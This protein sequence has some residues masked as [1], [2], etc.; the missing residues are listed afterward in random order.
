MKTRKEKRESNKET[1]YFFEFEKII[2]HF[3]KG[4]QK[5]LGKVEDGRHS[6]YISYPAELILYQMILKNAV[7][8]RSMRGMSE[9]FNQEK[10]IE[11]LRIA[12]KLKKLEEIPHYDTVNDFLSKLAPENLERIR[13]QM[14]VSLLK[15]RC[16]EGGR[17]LRKYWHVVVDGTGLHRFRERHCEHC[18]KRV[19]TDKETGEI[20]TYYYH[21]VLEAKLIVGKMALSLAT[22]FIENESVDVEKQDCEIKAFY[23]LSKKLKKDY[24]RLP[25]CLSGDSLYACEPVFQICQANRWKY[26]SRFK[27]G[28]I[29]TIDR[30]FQTLK[31]LEESESKNDGD[32][33][34]FNK[35]TY[36]ERSV[37]M[38]EYRTLEKKINKHFVFITNL[39]ITKKNVME[40]IVAGRNRWKIE[41]VGFNRQKNSRYN[42]EHVNS[43]DYTAM[44]NH[45][46]LVQITDIIVQ[47]YEQGSSA[48]SNF[49]RSIKKISSDLLDSFRQCHLTT[50]DI[51]NLTNPTQVRFAT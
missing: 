27:A 46:L 21:H 28:S 10:C 14:I 29:P 41:N 45:Y 35:I 30:E 7:D 26:I 39:E 3:F 8:I 34:F 18:L 19:I 38:M 50:E 49:K 31:Q 37:N 20:T 32:P 17:I 44:K 2:Q 33:V 4:F 42:I 1:N 25:I 36:N 16:L 6:S 11:N 12:L 9:E 13:K 5:S 43:H 15:K 24:P 40:L 47:L 51:I 48:L 23:R 22:E